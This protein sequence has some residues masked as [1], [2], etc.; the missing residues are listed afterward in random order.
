MVMSNEH[1]RILLLLLL[2]L[3]R[4]RVAGAA[5]LRL[6]RGARAP[7]LAQAPLQRR[8]LAAAPRLEP[9]HRPPCTLAAQLHLPLRAEL[10]H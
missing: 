3:L 8:A 4:V 5:Q 10:T 9:A 2:L 6:G 1:L 7:L